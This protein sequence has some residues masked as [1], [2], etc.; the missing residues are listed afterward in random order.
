[1][2]GIVLFRLDSLVNAGR[3]PETQYLPY[4]LWVFRGSV[5]HAGKAMIYMEIKPYQTINVTNFWVIA[6]SF[7]VIKTEHVGTGMEMARVAF[8]TESQ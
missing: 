4:I 7:Q 3:D 6:R 1:M 8:T 5:W 2:E